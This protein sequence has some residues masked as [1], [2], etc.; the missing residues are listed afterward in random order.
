MLLIILV[1]F[2]IRTE[3]VQTY[4]AKKAA[5]YLQGVL[6]T[7]V[8]I[9]RVAI[10]LFDRAFIDGI[11]IEDLKG[12]TLMYS[13]EIFLN[14]E[15]IGLTNNDFVLNEVSIS[16]AK[17]KL[18][19][20]RGED[21]LNLQFFIDAFES[22]R[23][24]SDPPEFNIAV[25]KVTLRNNR[26]V[27]HDQNMA[28]SEYG[29]DFSHLDLRK[30]DIDAT[31]LVLNP[32][33]YSANLNKISMY[34]R[35]GFSLD[36]MSAIAQFN[37][38]GVHTQKLTLK[39]GK[40]VIQTE[41]F[42]LLVNKTKD[43]N[44]FVDS[45]RFHT[46]FDS[47]SISMEE[48]AMF[49]PALRGMEQL[50]HIHGAVRESISG[51][52]LSDFQLVTGN[53]TEIRGNFV[54]PDFRIVN[55]EIWIEEIQRLHIDMADLVAIRLPYSS[56]TSFIAL[57]KE[58]MNLKYIEG[59][60]ITFRGNPEA[61]TVS[62]N[63]LETELGT[64]V[65]DENLSV[66]HDL[67]QDGYYFSSSDSKKNYITFE[68][69]DLGRMIDN[70]QLGVIHGAFGFDAK[71]IASKGLEIFGIHG[72]FKNLMVAGYTY[73]NIRIP[74]AN[75]RL[76]LTKSIPVSTISGKIIIGDE[77]LDL[78]Y[79]G[80]M[81]I[82]DYFNMNIQ[83][84][85]EC[86]NLSQLHPSL[87]NRG[88]LIS[89]VIISGKGRNLNDFEGDITL[90]K[91]S[92]EESGRNVE[93]D[94]IKANYKRDPF[95]D[96]F[97]LRSDLVDIDV[98]GVIDFN[99][100]TDNIVYQ[101]SLIFPSF[102]TDID[103]VEDH[104]S[105]IEYTF[106]F[107]RINP[108]MRIFYPDL[109]IA[110]NTIVSGGYNGLNNFFNLNIRGD[111][112]QYQSF[113]FEELNAFQ[114]LEKNEITASYDIGFVRWNDSIA[115]QEIHFVNLAS[116]DFMDSQLMFRDASRNRSNFEWQTQIWESEGFD[117]DLRPSFFTINGHRWDL[118]HTAHIN[119]SQECFFIENLNFERGNQQIGIEGQLSQIPTDKLH[120][121]VK[122]L[123][124]ED[125]GEVF[126]DHMDMHGIA[127]IDGFIANPF[128][129]I[130]FEGTV[131]VK[132]LVLDYRQIGDIIFNANL[133]VPNEK[134]ILDGELI[135]RESRTFNFDGD[136]YYKKEK[137]NIDF[138]LKFNNT[139]IAVLNSFMD[140][141][142]ITDISGA[143]G[144]NLTMKGTFQEPE[145]KGRLNIINGGMRMALLQ[146]KFIFNGQLI[147]DEM[148][149]YINNM[150][151]TDEEGNTG[152]ITGTLFH[153]NFSNFLYEFVVNMEEH[154]TM[155]NPLNRAEP[156]LIDRF[157]VMKTQYEEGS[158]YYGTAYVTGTVNI[159][160]YQ[161]K[162]N[163]N[164]DA[165][166]RRGTY[167]DFPM[168][169][170]TTLTEEGFITFK[171]P[172]IDEELLDETK[173]DFTNVSMSLN[174]NVTA[175][176]RVKLIFDPTIGD[177][178]TAY[179]NGRIKLG[180]DKYGDITMDGTYTLTD[181]AYN[182]AMGP[183][184]QNFFI[185]NGGTIRW[186]GSPYSAD[187]NVRTYI[188]TVANMTAVMPDAVSNRGVQNEEIYSYLTLTGD[189]NQ[190]EISFDLA[191]PKATEAN[192]TILAR[193][194]SDPDELNRQFFSILIM[195][196][197]LPL[198]GQE[199]RGGSG[200]N[201]ALDLLSTQI[202]SILSKV[203]EDYKMK[204]NLDR[205]DVTGAESYEFG[206]SKSFLDNRLLVSG[207]FGVGTYD[208]TGQAPQNNII[209]DINVE[210]LLNEE[211]TFRVNAFNVS[212]AHTVVQ[213]T[214][215]GMFTQGVG[216]NYIEDFN[217][218]EDF[219]LIQ[220]IF[221]VFRSNESRKV[222][223]KK[224]EKRLT[225]IPD[226]YRQPNEGIKEEE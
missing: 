42:H 78:V 61:F 175:D 184:K 123:E 128:E 221:D 216:V 103:P 111:Y 136:Y 218:V 104:L 163:I 76:D 75:Y 173:I 156:M 115:F 180:L 13:G 223:G 53:K 208:R 155:R 79:T 214:Q 98:S 168:Y 90:S 137:E 138:D 14:I 169:G 18:K 25:N 39:A 31:N 161:D 83:L 38:T 160:G 181:G 46:D 49:V 86:A 51:L 16:D 68:N 41:E 213:H 135:F 118:N 28:Q 129:S 93:L 45:V 150:P 130:E 15:L 140:P 203:S 48:I 170:P 162:L 11:Y 1:A 176:A 131:A 97:Y 212:N 99:K 199:A 226:E 36:H 8:E 110:K 206:I 219:K 196:R 5:S 54:L 215:M 197:F 126:L 143:L 107:K 171:T 33:G 73:K 19:K 174:F 63:R 121:H 91:T 198:S 84:D 153:E 179:G 65:F 191:A 2:A 23:T 183:Y 112:V 141:L 44:Q 189:M 22:E 7:R 116:N 166:T 187:L 105:Q 167:I 200:G 3:T 207:S 100:I 12:D 71:L 165:T 96:V 80:E 188:R 209:G 35:S 10:T 106:N 58:L 66:V 204:V 56:A 125:V 32:D 149:I 154:P 210:Y 205:D 64:I 225:P 145:L 146:A 193:I 17:F 57:P 29:V 178:I 164:V 85:I 26:F 134:I 74:A 192:K 30:I 144:G 94:S 185:E 87:V 122:N 220:A 77:N 27:Y 190:P 109:L 157:L 20:Y 147:A 148:G 70:N 211:G 82:S 47:S 101:S 88:E 81:I 43:F 159:S 62:L 195:K 194:K 102:F 119:Y 142:V 59:E 127:N 60:R 124:L 4:I 120:I 24:S 158:I 133:D 34:D 152:S 108:L 217:N 95:K 52:Q 222:L 202:N 113:K 9:D 92:Y 132:G 21:V 177:E 55:D 182:F 201:A 117:I 186:M 6:G 172:I 72:D 114:R 40:T 50:I 139:D 69:F 224:R 151:V 89:K 67:A 37:K